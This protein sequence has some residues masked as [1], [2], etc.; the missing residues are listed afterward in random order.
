MKKFGSFVLSVLFFCWVGWA[1]AQADTTKEGIVQVPVAQLY[2][3]TQTTKPL[4]IDVRT[5]PEYEK[6]HI[7]NVR[8]IPL[9]DL[10]ARMSE[11]RGNEKQPIYIVCASGR[12]SQR[13]AVLLKEK[14]FTQPMNVA[15]GTIAWIAAGYPVV[16]P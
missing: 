12:R 9:S 7:P 6:A 13:A 10:E 14:G 2:P 1:P 16:K 4:I 8:W 3:K 5:K 15:G 11:L